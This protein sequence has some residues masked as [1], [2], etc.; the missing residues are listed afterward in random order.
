MTTDHV[1]KTFNTD[2]GTQFSFQALR[3]SDYED[4][5]D[6]VCIHSLL[7]L[8]SCAKRAFGACSKVKL[9]IANQK[10]CIQ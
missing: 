2:F 5:L 9:H 10:I 6:P 4:V 3:L 7:A 1:T 8:V